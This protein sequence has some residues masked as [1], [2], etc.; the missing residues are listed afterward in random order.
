V[1]E[2]LGYGEEKEEIVQLIRVG[3]RNYAPVLEMK[4][5]A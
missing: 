2:V 1:R 5:A 3:N 4:N